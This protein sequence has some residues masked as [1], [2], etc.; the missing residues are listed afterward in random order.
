MPTQKRKRNAMLRPERSGQC[1]S[2]FNVNEMS[3]LLL[4][5]L[6]MC[7][8]SVIISIEDEQEKKRKKYSRKGVT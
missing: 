4:I 7:M 8:N 1:D 6:L 2:R 5:L 3:E